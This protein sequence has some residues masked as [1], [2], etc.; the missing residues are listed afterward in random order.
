MANIGIGTTYTKSIGF[1]CA[2]ASDID[3]KRMKWHAESYPDCDHVAGDIYNDEVFN[4]LVRLH[5]LH[6]C[7]GVLASPVCKDHSNANIHKNPNSKRA[8]LITRVLDFVK[9]TEP[10]FVMIENVPGFL[11]ARPAVLKGMPIEEYITDELNKLGY[12]V[13]IAVQDVADFGTPQSR[14]RA[15]VLASKKEKWEFPTPDAK[16]ITLRKVIGDLPS[17]EA[18]QKSGIKWHDAPE[19]S[20]FQ[21][22]VMHHTPSGCSAH[23]NLAP[24]KP[25]LVDGS[26][27]K[28]R[29]KCSYQRKAWDEPSNTIMCDSKGVSGF[30]TIHPGR[31]LPDGTYS[32]ARAMTILELLRIYG[33]PDDF[34]IPTWASDNFIRTVLGEQFAAN[35]VKRLLEMLPR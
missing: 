9:A 28:A 6:N 17:I 25:C 18:G 13:N 22:E 30:R 2:V 20:P 29:F 7:T 10:E 4:E 34:H 3:P 15:I 27:A 23:D 31:L 26:P 32:D 16:Q 14:K 8:L 24:W 1:N 21:A 11:K 19:M 35:H 12:Y 5:I 33:L